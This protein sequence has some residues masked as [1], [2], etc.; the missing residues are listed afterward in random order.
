M[1]FGELKKQAKMTPTIIILASVGS[2]T[3]VDQQTHSLLALQL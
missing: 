3:S 2:F 1:L